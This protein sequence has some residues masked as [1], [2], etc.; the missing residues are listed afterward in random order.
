MNK[1]TRLITPLLGIALTLALVA[2]V[3][4]TLSVTGG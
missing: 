2:F 1:H 3:L 4:V